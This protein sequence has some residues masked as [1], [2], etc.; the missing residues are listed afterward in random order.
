ML[1][2]YLVR[3]ISGFFKRRF[4]GFKYNYIFSGLI[5]IVLSCALNS[6]PRSYT[7]WHLPKI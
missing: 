4:S 2:A 1:N 6:Q 3:I 5:N 7:I